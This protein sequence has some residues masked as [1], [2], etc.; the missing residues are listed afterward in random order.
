MTKQLEVVIIKTERAVPLWARQESGQLQNKVFEI[1]AFLPW[2]LGGGYF[3]RLWPKVIA[4]I[5]SIS[6]A[7]VSVRLM[8]FLLSKLAPPFL[9]EGSISCFNRKRKAKENKTAPDGTA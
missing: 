4:A 6:S 2:G 9:L 5:T 1:A 3:F 8:G 7:I